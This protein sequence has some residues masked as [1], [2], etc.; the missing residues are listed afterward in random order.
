[1]ANIPDIQGKPDTTIFL[2]SFAFWYL[3]VLVVF[4][5]RIFLNPISPAHIMLDMKTL[6]NH[7]T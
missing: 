5:G 7:G 3:L 6:T 2:D 4:V 1:M